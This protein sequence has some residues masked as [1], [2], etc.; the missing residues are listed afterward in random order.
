MDI[1]TLLGII[2]YL[3]L[4][5]SYLFRWEKKR[6]RRVEQQRQWDNARRDRD[7][8]LTAAYA[9]RRDREAAL[10]AAYAREATLKKERASIRRSRGVSDHNSRPRGG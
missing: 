1:L 5:G 4:F 3:I 8:T 10:A 6:Q 2:L 9:R 7:A